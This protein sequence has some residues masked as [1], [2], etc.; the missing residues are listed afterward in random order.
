MGYGLWA[1]GH[2]LWA[3]GYGLWAVSYGLWAMGYE[4]W[5]MGYGP[6]AMGFGCSLLQLSPPKGPS[7]RGVV[8]LQSSIAAHHIP[9]L[10]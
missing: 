10:C 3:M 6:W 1:M 4:R 9:F 8:Q 5:A 7:Q 2:G